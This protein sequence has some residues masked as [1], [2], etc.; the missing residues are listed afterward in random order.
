MFGIDPIYLAILGLGA[1][2]SFAASMYVKAA[3]NSGAQIGLR[4]GLT[5]AEIA[6]R[7]LR[8]QGVDNVEVHEHQGFL[9]DHYNPMA[10]TLNLSPDVYHG[11]SAAA[12]GV[13]AHEVG[14]ALQHAQGDLSMWARSILVYPAYF[15]SMI[16]PWLVIAGIAMAT[17]QG[18]VAAHSTG[19]A[20]YLAIGGVGLFGVAFAL[21][22]FIV[23]NEFN[24]SARA[25]VLLVELGVTVPGEEDDTV[26]R[27]LLAA[28]LTYVAA[29]L[30]SLMQLL[31]WAWKAGLIGGQRRE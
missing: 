19:F 8:S 20:Y 2:M 26:R 11:R 13:A 23:F 31:Y 27:V 17:A 25:R 24:A 3:F 21:S 14:H 30:N 15:G 18:T 6:R 7:I 4:S 22:T 16:G 12:A 5:G 10:K 28:G 29:A 9:S 1:L